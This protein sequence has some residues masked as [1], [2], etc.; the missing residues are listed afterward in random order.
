MRGPGTSLGFLLALTS[1]PVGAAEHFMS[2]PR[3]VSTAGQAQI[4]LADDWQ[5][6]APAEAGF[7]PDVGARLD[8][9]VARGDFANL[10]AV[11]VVR[12][13]KLVLERYHAGRDE[14]WGQPLGT[15]TFGPEVKHDI[16]SISKSIVGLLYGIALAEGKV[17]ALERPLVDQFPAYEDLAADPARRRMTIAHALSMTLG[18][19]WDESLPY[20]DPRNSE[21]AMEMARDRYRFVLDRPIV[22]EPGSRWIY[23]G[24][25]TAVLGHLIAE[26]TGTPLVDFAR[27][28]LFEPLGVRDIDWVLGTNGEPAAASGLRMRP[29][30][31]AKI[32]QLVLD[33]G[34]RG[35]R[36]VVPADWLEESLK[37]RI[38]V[39]DGLEY[40]YQ[41]WLGRS[42]EDG[43]PWIAGFGNGG[44]RLS[45]IPGRDLVV[46]VMAGNYNAPDSWKLPTAIMSEILMPALRGE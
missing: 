38:P 7:A 8:A 29:R 3:G 30:D 43:Q 11:V 12:H 32:G 33:R 21:I 5:S 23:N 17:P 42:P 41:W 6:I 40:G 44:Q 20:S 10:H 16:R 26:G 27:A 13:G 1:M 37:P 22:A 36:Q 4:A 39:E 18:T 31:L 45:V 28:R 35:G 24:G 9:A 2:P 15:V 19:E 14:R 34:R 25:T 46:V